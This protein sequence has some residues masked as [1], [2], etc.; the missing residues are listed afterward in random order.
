MQNKRVLWTYITERLPWKGGFKYHIYRIIKRAN[1]SIEELNTIITETEFLLNCRSTSFFS[2][3][4]STPLRLI[5]FIS[6][7]INTN[8]LL[9]FEPH[10]TKS[11]LY[12]SI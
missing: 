10:T 11:F 7:N 3:K 1:I 6:S 9:P 5:D 2:E 12:S 4:S 8:L